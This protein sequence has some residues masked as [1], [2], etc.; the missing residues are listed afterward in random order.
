MT[1]RWHISV[2]IPA[3]DEEDLLPRCL[4]SVLEARASVLRMA[5]CDVV[6]AVDNSKDGTY[7]IARKIL[8]NA[9]GVIRCKAGRVGFAR[10]AAAKTALRRGKQNPSR[11]WLANTDADC[12][13]PPTWLTDQLQ[14][15]QAGVEA[16]AGIVDVDSFD[17]HGPHV[18]ERFRSTYVLNP[19]GTHPHIHGANLGV[20]ADVYLRAGGWANLGT[21]EDHDL[22]GRL[23]VA[24]AQKLSTS[25]LKVLT[26]GRRCGRAP[27]G[28]AGALAAHNEVRVEA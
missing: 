20:R 16:I 4:E 2:L 18:R 1:N 24:G 13:V 10:A 8:G 3:R 17:E 21:A 5:S 12:C 11:V 14:L 9:G 23:A 26:S 6:V 19:D 15:A 28:F 7:G 22:W 25:R 27:M